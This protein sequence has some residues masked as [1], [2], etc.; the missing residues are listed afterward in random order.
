MLAGRTRFIAQR[1]LC[2]Y[3]QHEGAF[4]LY[5]RRDDTR[6]RRIRERLPK[7]AEHVLNLQRCSVTGR[8]RLSWFNDVP[9]ASRV[10]RASAYDLAS[11]HPCR[12]IRECLRACSLV[13]L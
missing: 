10:V 1:D 2:S 6:F 9:F 3:V 11:A 7:W 4:I 5:R 8:E 12:C 13:E